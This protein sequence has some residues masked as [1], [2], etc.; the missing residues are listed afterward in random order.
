MDTLHSGMKLHT[1][2]DVRRNF[3]IRIHRIHIRI[4]NVIIYS[5]SDM[6]GVKTR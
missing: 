4:V 2:Y 3:H 5:N 1:Q 6:N